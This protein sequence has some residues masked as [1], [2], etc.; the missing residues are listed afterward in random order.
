MDLKKFNSKRFDYFVL[1]MSF[2]K[3]ILFGINISFF[4]FPS[5]LFRFFNKNR[6]FNYPFYPLIFVFLFFLGALFSFF[7]SNV[8]NS[9]SFLNSFAVLFN[10]IYWCILVFILVSIRRLLNYH[11]ILKYL[12]IGYLLYFV[13]QIVNLEIP[14]LLQF[15]SPNSFAFVSI[16]FTGI[17]CLF[18]KQKLGLN[19]ALLFLF[20]ILYYLLL[21]G[22]RAGLVLV[23]L[24]SILSLFSSKIS[25]KNILFIGIFLLLFLFI[26]NLEFVEQ[27]IY[28]NNERIYG[29]LYD[30][31]N[32][33]QEDRSFLTRK[34]MIEK[35]LLIFHDHPL[36]GIGLN[37]FIGY[38]VNFLGNFEGSQFVLSKADMNYK[39]A[40]NSYAS[41]LAEGG[42]LLILPVV[43]LILY[44]VYHFILNYNSKNNLFNSFYYCFFAMC[45]HLYYI[46]ALVNVYS[47]FMIGLVCSI[48]AFLNDQSRVS[49]L[50]IQST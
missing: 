9:F 14:S 35:A 45:I 32:Q 26:L 37:N 50:K 15:S 12:S 33:L 31:E 10:Y 19:F 4:L 49:K 47:W 34:L 8:S 41:F 39:S 43:F 21:N 7:D 2:S 24:S 48:S 11:T 6:S 16:C 20:S 23:F 13:T 3:I 27:F 28:S 25:F 42:L 18:L 1:F 5:F 40:H 38:E 17:T 46:S 44:N 30:S 22:R 36:T 29:F